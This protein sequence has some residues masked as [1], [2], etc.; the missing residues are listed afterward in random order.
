MH[1]FRLGLRV[2]RRKGM[3][4]APISVIPH[5]PQ[6]GITRVKVGI[7]THH[8]LGGNLQ[9]NPLMCVYIFSIQVTEKVKSEKYTIL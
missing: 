1:L 8:P 6:N 7:K 4:N 9:E 5:Y 2:G 3:G